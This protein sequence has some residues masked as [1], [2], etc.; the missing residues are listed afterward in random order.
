MGVTGQPPFNGKNNNRIFLNIVKQ[1]VKFP[2]HAKLSDTLKNFILTLLNKDP[3]KRPSA[4]EALSHPF[5]SG[6]TKLSDKGMGKEVLGFLSQFKHESRLKKKLAEVVIH[7]APK[8]DMDK[9]RKMFE[10]V[11]ADG[12][13]ELTVE[14]LSTILVNGMGYYP[15]KALEQAQVIMT[16]CDSNGDGKLSF[17]EFSHVHASMQLSSDDMLIHTCFSVMDENGD[18]IIELQEL[19]DALKLSR[20]EAEIVFKEADLDGDGLISFDEFKMAMA[21]SLQT[22]RLSKSRLFAGIGGGADMANNID[23]EIDRNGRS[24]FSKNSSSIPSSLNNKIIE[25]KLPDKVDERKTLISQN[26]SENSI[27][28][29]EQNAM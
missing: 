20:E 29:A 11:D 23:L 18:G 14:E 10:S 16:K 5:V 4:K 26:K 13:G 25:E 27:A 21:G 6:T 9:L 2:K 17:D 1:S 19:Q 24:S 3:L 8:K 7:Y 12:D 22:D 15:Q 28:P